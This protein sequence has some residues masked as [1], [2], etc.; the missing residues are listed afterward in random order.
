VLED[1]SLANI[2]YGVSASSNEMEL[3]FKEC[4]KSLLR[5][6]RERN[7]FSLT[8]GIAPIIDLSKKVWQLG[9]RSRWD[10]S[11]HILIELI[12]GHIKLP[13]VEK[14]VE[15]MLRE[16]FPRRISMKIVDKDGR[17]VERPDYRPFL[18]LR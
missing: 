13:E 10:F 12:E 7:L 1:N 6:A 11:E 8:N 5:F 18:Y 2:E 4:L 17:P 3:A 15:V 16:D 9:P 14:C